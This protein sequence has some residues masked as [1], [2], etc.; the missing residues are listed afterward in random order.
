MRYH[1]HIVSSLAIGAGIATYTSIS[2]LL[3]MQPD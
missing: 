3:P 2:L 1:T